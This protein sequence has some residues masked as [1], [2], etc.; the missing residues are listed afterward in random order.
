MSLTAQSP[1]LILFLT[2]YK[3]VHFLT[4]LNSA[5][6]MDAAC[7]SKTMAYRKKRRKSNNPKDHPVPSLLSDFLALFT[8]AESSIYN[9][10]NQF[11]LSW[12]LL[13]LH[14]YLLL[15]SHI[16]CLYLSTQ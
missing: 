11:S 5:L 4:L 14:L 16:S 2:L 8:V 12:N 13:K 3:A 9:I 1:G 15:Y 10:Y 6:K 7:S